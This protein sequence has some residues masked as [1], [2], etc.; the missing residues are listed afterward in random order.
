MYDVTVVM[1]TDPFGNYMVQKLI[2]VASGESRRMILARICVDAVST[3]CNMHGTR[4]IQKAVE[5]LSDATEVQMFTDALRDSVASMVK[6]VNGNHVIQKC[7]STFTS[8][9]KQFIFDVIAEQCVDI[10]TH[11]HGCC[12]MQRCFDHGSDAQKV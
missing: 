6:D 9:Q 8:E 7:L 5:C 1:T 3:A 10:A 12:V 4:T 11:R 2:E